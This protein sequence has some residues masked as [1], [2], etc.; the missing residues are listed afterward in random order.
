MATLVGFHISSESQYPVYNIPCRKCR[1]PLPLQCEELSLIA[2]HLEKSIEE[3]KNLYESDMVLLRSKLPKSRNYRSATCPCPEPVPAE[4]LSP[5]KPCVPAQLDYGE[6]IYSHAECC[7]GKHKIYDILYTNSYSC[8]FC[9]KIVCGGPA[10]FIKHVKNRHSPSSRVPSRPLQLAVPQQLLGGT[11]DPLCRQIVHNGSVENGDDE[12]RGLL[13]VE[14][15]Y[16]NIIKRWKQKDGKEGMR[17]YPIKNQVCTSCAHWNAVEFTIPAPF[18]AKGHMTTIFPPHAYIPP[19]AAVL[20][21]DIDYMGPLYLLDPVLGLEHARHVADLL[22]RPYFGKVEESFMYT[23][24][25]PRAIKTYIYEVWQTMLYTARYGVAG[26]RWKTLEEVKATPIPGAM[27]LQAINDDIAVFN[28]GL[29]MT[30]LPPVLC[31][32]IQEFMPWQLWN[33]QKILHRIHADVIEY[34]PK[35]AV[36]FSKIGPIRAI[37]YY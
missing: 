5:Q 21:I 13:T 22:K 7:C 14:Q 20:P 36:L 30:S 25:Y 27:V 18:R 23:T 35:L 11:W 37:P 19:F 31:S 34:A 15:I 9:Y 12:W 17:I 3:I 10:C 4:P 33:M 26:R 1:S 2:L 29:K 32:V 24:N 8:P 16:D 6:P 28:D